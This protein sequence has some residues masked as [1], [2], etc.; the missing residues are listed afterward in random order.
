MT[1]IMKW[2]YILQC[3]DG[4]FYVGETS[5]L[6][7]RFWE[8]ETG[9]GGL[10]TSTYI[11]TKCVSI[12]SVNR[13]GK[14][15]RYTEN[16]ENNIYGINHNIYFNRSVISENIEDD[17]DW[18]YDKLW[19]ENTITE[20]LM[21]DN[22]ENWEKIR[23]GKYVKF[24]VEYTFP[25]NKFSKE[26]PNCSCGFPC[27]VKHD[28][29]NNYLYFRCAKKNIWE[30]M[31]EEFEIH[32]E[33]C[34]FFMKYTND[35]PYK[36]EYEKYKIKYEKRKQQIYS[37]TDKS[38]WLKSLVGGQYEYCVGGCGK[39]YNEN[40][41]VRYSRRAINLCFDCFINKNQ[42]LSKKYNKHIPIGKCLIEL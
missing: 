26:L 23:G 7:R 17:N 3:E 6:Y 31:R 9:K 20:K 38:H 24:N 41:T 18:G 16:V 42:E 2:V 34:N 11:P 28:K 33:P 21:I 12:Y 19:V 40:N 10:N 13:L 5:R 1:K 35:E 36:I 4:Y 8:H 30:S 39:E 37:L 29:E 27:D 22:E 14:F 25:N 15:F 32:D